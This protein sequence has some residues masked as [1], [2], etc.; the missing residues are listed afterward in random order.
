M[1][2]SGG[3]PRGVGEPS[4]AIG[5][6]LSTGPLLVAHKLGIIPLTQVCHS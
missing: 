5:A 6:A 4:E 3:G 2:A 1:A